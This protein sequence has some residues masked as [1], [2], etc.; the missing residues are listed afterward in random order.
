MKK[1]RKKKVINRVADNY[2]QLKKRVKP[3]SLLLHQ[4]TH[5][6]CRQTFLAADKT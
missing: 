6:M 5:R 4:Q 1:V 3:T 2:E